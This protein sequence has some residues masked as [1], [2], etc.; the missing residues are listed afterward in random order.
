MNN[1]RVFVGLDY[2]TDV[3][4]VCV[5]DS[6]GAV[7]GNRGC[8]N[9]C[10]E[11][12]GYVEKFGTVAG[13]ALEACTGAANLA[14]ELVLKAGWSVDLGHPGYVARIKQSP[15]KTDWQDARLLADLERVGYLPKVWQAPEAVR[16]LRQLVRYRQ[17]IVD[18]KR[19][20]KLR[21]RAVLRQARCLD[22]G[23]ADCLE[24][25]IAP[26]PWTKV[27]LTWLTERA[28]L[29]T[30]SRWVVDQL[31][32]EL[33]W[34]EQRLKVADRRLEEVT[35]DDTEVARLQQQPGIGPVTAWTLRAE[36]GRF[37]RFRSGKQLSRFCGLS[38]CN[39]SSGPRQADAGLIRAANGRLRAV[40]IEAAH[41][42]VQHDPRYKTLA[43]K[44]RS[45]GKKGSVVAAAIA[46]R[47]V[48]WLYHQMVG[49]P[50][51]PGIPRTPGTPEVTTAA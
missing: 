40:L 1:L 24:P 2:S 23:D 43:L 29:P 8:R 41:R 46:N 39:A 51:T 14:D 34:L 49:S 35:A 20:V 44:L 25:V 50:G 10:R 9:D 12:R 31:L 37:D 33:T 28:V 17:E 27:W 22:G 26:R 18:Q 32:A 19:R 7:L 15:D 16:E 5:M 47:W 3:V 30:Q 11:I 48:R 38:P 6:A 21:I 36:I 4:Q 13:A 42:L 45:R